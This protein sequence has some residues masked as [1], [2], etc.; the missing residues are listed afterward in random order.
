MLYAE[1]DLV[2]ISALQHIAFCERQCALIHVEQVWEENRLTVEGRN[3]HDRVHEA[4]AESRPGIRIVRGLRLRS[5][6][7]G[8][9][10]IADV[11]EFHSVPQSQI[12][13]LRSQKP[14]PVEYKRGKTKVDDCDAIQLCAQAI[15]L[16]EMLHVAIPCGALFYGISRRRQNVAFDEDLRALTE[17][18]AQ[19]VHAL[20]ESG[21]T[22]PAEYGPKCENCSLKEICLPKET[23][24]SRSASGYLAKH[25]KSLI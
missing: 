9:T 2:P 19:R 3:L 24:G 17:Q 13:D 18:S 25:L 7:L 11:V 4:D 1:D 16:E 10:G 6:R 12:S 21:I 23:G 5:L 15:C 22:P 20:V 14:F 8:L